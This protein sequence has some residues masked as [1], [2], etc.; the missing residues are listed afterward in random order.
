M[1]QLFKRRTGHWKSRRLATLLST[2][3]RCKKPVIN[4]CDVNAP[5]ENLSS[6]WNRTK[7]CHWARCHSNHINPAI[8]PLMSFALS[9]TQKPIIQSCFTWVQGHQ[10]SPKSPSIAC[11]SSLNRRHQRIT[12]MNAKMGR[13]KKKRRL[14]GWWY[15]R[16]GR[17]RRMGTKK[18]RQKHRAGGAGETRRK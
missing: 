10:A 7:C 15:W 3:P 12:I 14:G 4:T 5:T 2:Q 16:L 1:L 11:C 9:L 6:K 13:H 18:T 17:R 8:L